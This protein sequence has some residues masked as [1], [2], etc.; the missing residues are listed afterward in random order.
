MSP[1]ADLPT[2]SR[3]RTAGFLWLV[4]AILLVALSMVPWAVS[5][6]FA[7]RTPAPR[8]W[9]AS[10]WSWRIPWWSGASS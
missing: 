10:W 7:A 9:R 1:A 6:I 4:L 5:A 8:S 3:A 2:T